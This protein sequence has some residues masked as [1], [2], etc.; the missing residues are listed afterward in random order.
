MHIAK[1]FIASPQARSRPCV[2][3]YRAPLYRS[4]RRG[5]RPTGQHCPCCPERRS[6]GPCLVPNCAQTGGFRSIIREVRN[7]GDWMVEQSGFELP[8]PPLQAK[9]DGYLSVP[10]LS[11]SADQRRR[12][13]RNWLRTRY[14]DKKPV[15]PA[16][17]IHFAPPT[18]H[19][20][21]VTDGGIAFLKQMF[22]ERRSQSLGAALFPYREC[23]ARST[24]DLHAEDK[25]RRAVV[26][27]TPSVL[28]SLKTG[29]PALFFAVECHCRLP[30]R[31]HLIAIPP[32]SIDYSVSRLG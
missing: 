27:S 14:F 9:V 10:L 12:R 13:M 28:S 18:S 6:P 17:R 8:V 11:V 26:D 5:E 25:P 1:I 29:R 21:P 20:E 23:K 3:L 15:G 32:I 24:M 2:S 4:R 16:V 22:L 7:L 31:L 19:C 30:R